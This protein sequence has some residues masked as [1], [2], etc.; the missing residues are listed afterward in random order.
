M[1]EQKEAPGIYHHRA[2]CRDTNGAYVCEEK[3]HQDL[4][5]ESRIAVDAPCAHSCWLCSWKK[6]EG[7]E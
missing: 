4:T 1:Q 3:I 7:K 5:S 2:Y 6:R